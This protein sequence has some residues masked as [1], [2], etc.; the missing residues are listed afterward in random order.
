MWANQKVV[1]SMVVIIRENLLLFANW[2]TTACTGIEH[3]MAVIFYIWI[4]LSQLCS[5]I[6]FIFFMPIIL[7]ARNQ[8]L[9]TKNKHFHPYVVITKFEPLLKINKQ[10][11]KKNQRFQSPPRE[12]L[13]YPCYNFI[14]LDSFSKVAT[15]I[16]SVIL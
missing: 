2:I 7:Q 11:Y 3:T 16:Q 14:Y 5:Y 12:H 6:A 8:F 4:S 1:S 13:H 9:L 15:V 10:T